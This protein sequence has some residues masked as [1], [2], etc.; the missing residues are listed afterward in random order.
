[1][2]RINPDDPKWTAYI[3]GELDGT[4]RA[5]IEAELESSEE[6]RTLVDE[7]RFAGE[8][9]KTELRHAGTVTSLTPAQRATIVSSVKPLRTPSWFRFRP[10]VWAAGLAAAGLAAL[11]LTFATRPPLPAR[12][13]V[14]SALAPSPADSVPPHAE[15]TNAKDIA[16][17]S[18]KS[19]SEFELRQKQ[20]VPPASVIGGASGK[21]LELSPSSVS[22]ADAAAKEA[23]GATEKAEIDA[24]SAEM[25]M[26]RKLRQVQ[27]SDSETQIPE[28]PAQLS[29]QTAAATP[30]QSAAAA[31]AAVVPAAEFARVRSALRDNLKAGN[32]DEDNPFVTAAQNPR[33]T[34]A[35]EVGATSYSSVR[36]YLNQNQL[37]PRNAVQIEEMINYFDYSY[38]QPSGNATIAAAIEAASAP[39]NPQH[40]IIR[41]ALSAKSGDGEVQVDFSPASVEA[42]R[43]IGYE[44]ELSR[45]EGLA[46]AAKKTMNSLPA[47]HRISALYEVV[48][49]A[50][51]ASTPTLTVRTA[52][53]DAARRDGTSRS[54]AFIDRG[55]PFASS[56]S[57][58]RFAA[59]VASFGMILR[60]SPYKGTS[61]FE[62]VESIAANSLGPD[63]TGSRHEFLQLVRRARQIR[64]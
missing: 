15:E 44:S 43:L 1:M 16:A 37:P 46:E 7:L 19:T 57:D 9:A 62:S 29:A 10:A 39:W 5:A 53:T 49:A 59:A 28:S 4:E 20:A 42:Y 52:N 30:M 41:I 12:Q 63:P 11:V 58:F 31:K 55:Q 6:A 38:P 61:T 50:K 17:N 51:T 48:P 2:T 64:G 33:S 24:A 40:R 18:P 60:D 32:S 54:F 47:G 34:F 35:M 13:A 3:L 14:V 23:A 8:L 27:K 25:A 45:N 22:N 36:Q 56:S 21:L 26:D